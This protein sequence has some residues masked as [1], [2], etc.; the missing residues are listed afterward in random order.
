MQQHN[1][2]HD[3][4]VTNDRTALGRRRMT[5][6]QAASCLGVTAEAVRARIQ[7]GTL[8]HTREGKT[9]YVLLPTDRTQH[10]GA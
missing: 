5:V 2:H 1:D 10:D 7:R 4:D 3:A 8:E 9:V 6:A